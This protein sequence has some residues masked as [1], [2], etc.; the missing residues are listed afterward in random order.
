MNPYCGPVGPMSRL[1]KYNARNNVTATP[2][3]RCASCF[4][5]GGIVYHLSMDPGRIFQMANIVA[6]ILKKL[7]F[8][9]MLRQVQVKILIIVYSHLY[10]MINTK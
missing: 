6:G 2:F 10:E 9:T 7:H 8:N 4:E 1:N 5:T 3:Q